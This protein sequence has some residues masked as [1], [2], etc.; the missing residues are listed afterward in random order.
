MNIFNLRDHVID[1]YHQYVESFLNIR[2]E[3]IKEDFGGGWIFAISNLQIG[4]LY[5]N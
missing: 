5:V 1:D 2:E 3:Q 4:L